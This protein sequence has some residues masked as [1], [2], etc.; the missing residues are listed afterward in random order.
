MN[1]GQNL[2]RKTTLILGGGALTVLAL[3]GVA[4]A[5]SPDSGSKPSGE[6]GKYAT[7]D[8]NG[9]LTFSDTDPSAGKDRAPAQ[10]GTGKYATVD[11]NGKLTFSDTDP[12]A[13][14]DRAPAQPAQK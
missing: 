11:K 14:K 2:R 1:L 13:G 12:S 10:E 4:A 3:G 5:Q 9:K 8:K 6:T 7:V